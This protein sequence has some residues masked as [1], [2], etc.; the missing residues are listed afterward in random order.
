MRNNSRC[1]VDGV[2][3][4]NLTDTA[5][6]CQACC[7]QAYPNHTVTMDLDLP[8]VNLSRLGIDNINSVTSVLVCMAGGSRRDSIGCRGLCKFRRLTG[9][10][11]MVRRMNSRKRRNRPSLLMTSTAL[12]AT[13]PSR[14]R[15]PLSTMRGVAEPSSPPSLPAY[16]HL[17]APAL[18]SHYVASSVVLMTCHPD[19]AGAVTAQQ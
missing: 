3:W 18:L 15:K 1:G 11:R 5:M 10:C 6:Q 13:S 9:S 14:V 2:V 4:S 8:C 19:Q 17:K 7:M 12:F 16:H